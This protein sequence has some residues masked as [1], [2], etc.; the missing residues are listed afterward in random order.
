MALQTLTLRDGRT[1]EVD[2][3]VGASKEVLAQIASRQLSLQSTDYREERRAAEE[4]ARREQE[5]RLQFAKKASEEARLRRIEGKRG[6]LA[7]GLDIG[8]DLVG[9]ATGSALEGIGSLLGV[10]GLEQYGAEVALENEADAQ[11]KSRFQTRFDDIEGVGDFFSY[12]GGIAGESAPAMA[13]GI[14]GGITAAASAPL[15]G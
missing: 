14:V 8:T 4:R 6:S 10:E 11:R 2:A 5:E 7:R 1:L 15:W 13:A 12:L 9:Q 3:P